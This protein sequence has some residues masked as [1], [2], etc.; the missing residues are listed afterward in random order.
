M[1]D[2]LLRVLR[3]LTDA[4]RLRV[5]S[6]LAAGRAMT[7][8]EVARAAGATHPSA[9]HH[10]KRLRAAG[11]V[12]VVSGEG[13]PEA[14]YILQ[15]ERLNDAGRALD[16]VA[17]AAEQRADGHGTFED[18]TDEDARILRSFFNGERLVSIPAQEKKRLPVLRYLARTVFEGERE[19]PE[20]EVN[21]LLAL[22]HRDVASLRRYLVDYGFMSREA[23]V[24]RLRP[25]SDWPS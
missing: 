5:V 23:S 17:R 6:A 21:Q 14:R 20:K 11:L 2:D 3:A 4:P 13:T 9:A 7:L 24:Y 12:A 8:D 15:V 18:A 16:A 1:D 19:Y 25:E 10:L 22:R